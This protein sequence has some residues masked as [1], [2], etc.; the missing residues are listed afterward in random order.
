MKN[1]MVNLQLEIYKLNIFSKKFLFSIDLTKDFYAIGF[2]KYE[3]AKDNVSHQLRECNSKTPCRT[4]N[5]PFKK[6]RNNRFECINAE[7]FKSLPH[8]TLENSKLFKSHY[9]PDEF[10]EYS[11]NLHFAGFVE[12]RSSINGK[13]FHE[14]K[15][16]PFFPLNYKDAIHECPEDCVGQ[17]TCQCT[18]IIEIK[19]GRVIQFTFYH[20]GMIDGLKCTNHPLHLHGHH[21]YV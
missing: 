19:P 5:C 7:S 4:V 9:S 18:Q 3:N 2:L 21:F 16:P 14:P 17:K 13:Q 15:Q 6:G 1:L 20:M 12:A 8:Q 10:E 11:L